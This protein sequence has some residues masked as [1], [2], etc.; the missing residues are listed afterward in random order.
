MTKI[1]SLEYYLDKQNSPFGYLDFNEIKMK[2]P[3]LKQTTFNSMLLGYDNKPGRWLDVFDGVF[4]I[5]KNE[6][7][8]MAEYQ[9]W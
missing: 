6:P 5:K 1:N 7:L 8:K 3:K 9:I 4:Y 2:D